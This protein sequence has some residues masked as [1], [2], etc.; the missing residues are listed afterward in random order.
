[1]KA[2]I[3]V[4]SGDASAPYDAIL[5]AT[6]SDVRLVLVDGIALYGDD[7]LEPLG[8]P[9]PGCEAI[10]ICGEQKFLCV[11]IEGGDSTNKFGQTFAEIET[12]LVDALAAYDALDLSSWDFAPLTPLVTCP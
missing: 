10:D 11:A 6:P 2:D 5:A 4:A 9:T 1:M 3:A 7:Q 8:D 12:I